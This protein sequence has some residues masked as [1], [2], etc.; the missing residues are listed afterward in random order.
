MQARIELYRPPESSL[1]PATIA[2]QKVYM[3]LSRGREIR[4]SFPGFWT[5]IKS[6][7]MLVDPEQTGQQIRGHVLELADCYKNQGVK[8]PDSIVIGSTD[9]IRGKSQNT[10]IFNIKDR[11]LVLRLKGKRE[12]KKTLGDEAWTWY[13]IRVLESLR[14]EAVSPQKK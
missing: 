12:I 13:G 7:K 10:L 14:I 6:I 9:S 3:A 5:K 8:L 11:E 4:E 1:D 2:A